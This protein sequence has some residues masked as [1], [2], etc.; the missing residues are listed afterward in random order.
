MLTT[1]SNITSGETTAPND[2]G[3]GFHNSSLTGTQP[4]PALW[5]EAP[6]V[7]RTSLRYGHIVVDSKEVRNFSKV[8]VET[9]YPCNL[10]SSLSV[11]RCS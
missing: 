6:S 5:A 3:R 2:G 7:Q 10:Y 1:T 8:E 4:E 11:V 9:F